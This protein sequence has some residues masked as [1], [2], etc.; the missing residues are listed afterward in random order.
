[1]QMQP[2]EAQQTCSRGNAGA[3][4]KLRSKAAHNDIV[5]ELGEEGE[6]VISSSRCKHLISLLERYDL[7]QMPSMMIRIFFQGRRVFGC[8]YAM[9]S[10]SNRS[11]LARGICDRQCVAYAWPEG[12]ERLMT[13]IQ[14][15]GALA[16]GLFQQSCITNHEVY[17]AGKG[18]NMKL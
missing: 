4:V 3:E 12:A 18:W 16:M 15:S 5:R 9:L 13:S 7:T 11:R 2:A 17:L 14:A 6:G 8:P 1:M 10:L